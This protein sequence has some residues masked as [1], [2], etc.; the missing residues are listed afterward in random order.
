MLSLFTLTPKQ[1][2]DMQFVAALAPRSPAEPRKAEL[3]LPAPVRPAQRVSTRNQAA[4]VAVAAFLADRV[5]N[6]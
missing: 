2:C 6:P 3:S 4:W 1:V 5:V